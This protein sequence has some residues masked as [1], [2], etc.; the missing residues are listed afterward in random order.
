MEEKIWMVN[1][2]FTELN[3]KQLEGLSTDQLAIYTAD[4]NKAFVED[5][6]S[7]V[8]A[9]MDEKLKETLSKEDLETIKSD[10]AEGLK[11][12]DTEALA[13]YNET[14][15]ALKQESKD[16]LEL[17]KEVK[18]IARKQGL[19]IETNKGNKIPEA[20]KKITKEDQFKV[21]V[22]QAFKS[23]EFE[24]FQ[25]R[26]YKGYSE[27]MTLNNTKDGKFELN[28][29]ESKAVVPISTNHTGTVMISEISDIVRDD[30]PARKMHVRDLL[31]V[32][33]TDQ[34]QIVAGQVYEWTDALTLGAIMLSENGEAPESVFKSKENTWGLKRIANSMRISKRWLKTNGL[35]WV[36]DHVLAKLPDATYTV[37]DF[38][39]LFGDGSG[40]NV[41]GLAKN[42]QAFDLT[43]QVYAADDF[44]S[45][46]TWNS[47]TQALITFNV[48]HGMRNGDS[49]T[50]ANATEASYNATHTAVEVVNATQVI[51]DL[52]YVAETLANVAAWTGT[53]A[54]IFHLAIDD[55]QEYDVL[56]V[57]E[58][59]LEA[60]EFG[61]TGHVVNPQQ[62]IQMGLLKATDANYLNIQKDS[63]GR[64]IGVNGKPIATTTAVPAGKFFSGDFSRNGAELKEYTPFNIQ[65]VEDVETAKKNEIV[66]VVEE[67]II[68][69]IYNPYWFIYGKF[70]TAK[71][72]LETT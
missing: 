46:A 20:R 31:N 33:M 47:G 11:G 3:D 15:E 18:E 59:L 13:K 61:V 62:A 6:I 5:A 42:A 53:S 8:H 69:P 10:F 25:N 22:D 58:A 52:T 19:E 45:V 51:I 35:Q 21:L 36:I 65:F 57:A 55:A 56:A 66:I 37:E 43:P 70:A 34:A 41:D 54:S 9:Q 49:L 67:E 26:G 27:K 4:K 23:E 30:T 32:G 17:A 29:L 28:G 14:I 1:N 24:A 68:F 38:Q 64:V 71:T 44:E 50:I 48:N 12:L 72:Q 63:N 39:L 60:G 7:K 40:E 2:K 16:A